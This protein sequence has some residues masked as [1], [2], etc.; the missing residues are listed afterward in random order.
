MASDWK[1]ALS[2]LRDSGTLPDGGPSANDGQ[3]SDKS[4]GFKKSPLHVVVERKGRGG[5]T[6]TIIE[7]FDGPDNELEELARILKQKLGA[8]GSARGGEI[9]IQG[10]RKD[11]VKEIL[12]S[13]GYK[14]KG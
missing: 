12:K 2:A 13:L 9:L 6:A 7:G 4:S 8:G 1:D 5:K 3:D 11:D 10:N 14:T